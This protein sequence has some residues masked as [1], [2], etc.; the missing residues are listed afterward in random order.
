M[1]F[2]WLFNVYVASV[3]GKVNVKVLGRGLGLMG[4]LQIMQ[5]SWLTQ[6]RN[7][8]GCLCEMYNPTKG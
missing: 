1:I 2:L 4:Y 3:V 8:A 6:R 7:C 5:H